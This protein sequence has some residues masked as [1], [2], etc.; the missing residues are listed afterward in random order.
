[1][2]FR[3]RKTQPKPEKALAPKFAARGW[4]VLILHTIR[5]GHCSCT[6]GPDCAH[7]GKHPLPPHGVKDATNSKTEIEAW[8]NKWP[9]ANIG[10]ATGDRSG[11]FVLDVDGEIGKASLRALKAQHG[12]LPKTLDQYLPE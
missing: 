12:P 1:M 2:T 6:D 8:R 9:D 7:P 11:I 4:A 10:I 5:D 3:N